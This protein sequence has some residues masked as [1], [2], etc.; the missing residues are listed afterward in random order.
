M[1]TLV[2]G[3]YGNF[4]A[5]ICRALAGDAN[6]DLQIAGRNAGQA[7]RLADALGGRASA[8]A[9]DCNASDFAQALAALQVDLVIH[10]AGPFQEQSYAVAVAA[11]RAGAHYIDLADGRRFVCDFPGQLHGT[12]QQAGRVAISGASTV[13]ALSSAVVDHLSA[14]WR[15]L[16]AIDICIA[17]AQT[18]PRGRATLAAVLSY[19]GRPV[20]IWRGGQ[21]T[22]A[23]GWATPERVEFKR[24]HPRIGALC[25]IPDL[26]LFPARYGVRDRVMFRAALEVAATQR[27]FA[28]LAALRGMGLLKRPERLAG[29]LDRIS[30]VFDALGTSKGGMVVRIEGLDAAGDPARRAWHIAADNGDGPEIPCMA[31]ILLARKLAAGDAMAAGA[32]TAAG[33]LSL[34]EF[35]PEFARWGMLTDIVDEVP[36]AL[37]QASSTSSTVAQR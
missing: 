10:T 13:P 21:W 6:I 24:L 23:P 12:F 9:I 25:D 4:G 3:G 19:C 22:Q 29:I 14:G 33:L 34:D 36:A 30:G 32:Y 11:A 18:A 17:P 27:T 15:S 35:E 7:Q 1:K 31:A 16:H 8:V 26:E 2:L 20:R 28:V 37:P 5:R